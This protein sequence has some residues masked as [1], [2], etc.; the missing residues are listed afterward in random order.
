MDPP[1]TSGRGAN[2]EWV[3]ALRGGVGM[4][5]LVEDAQGADEPH[6]LKLQ[7]IPG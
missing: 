4:K 3:R 5:G 2:Q 6:G 7:F 1:G